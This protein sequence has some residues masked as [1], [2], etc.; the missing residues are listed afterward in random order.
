[1]TRSTPIIPV[2]A[3]REI[4]LCTTPTCQVNL[5]CAFQVL[6][7]FR[8]RLQNLVELPRSTGR[9]WLAVNALRV[10]AF[11]LHVHQQQLHHFGH[12]VGFTGEDTH[13]HPKVKGA[14]YTVV[15]SQTETREYRWDGQRESWETD[16]YVFITRSSQ[17]LPAWHTVSS[18]L[19]WFYSGISC[20]ILTC[21]L[22]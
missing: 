19:W 9:P 10:E 18:S 11:Q 13:M 8:T 22:T 7:E 20:D 5:I 14:W 21:K 3:T 6:A 15:L 17:F 16:M 1:M 2:N 4:T 12:R